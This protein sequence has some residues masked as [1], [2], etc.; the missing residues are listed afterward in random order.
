MLASIIA[1]FYFNNQY[2]WKYLNQIGFF[3]VALYG[4]ATFVLEP[5]THIF[6]FNF[7]VTENY[8]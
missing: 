2:C 1:D 7:S 4:A 6:H 8:K 3:T 5:V